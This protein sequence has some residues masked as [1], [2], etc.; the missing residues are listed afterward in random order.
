M[1]LFGPTME[2]DLLNNFDVICRAKPPE[3]SRDLRRYVPPATTV[4]PNFQRSAKPSDWTIF[5][6]PRIS[7]TANGGRG[8]VHTSNRE[9]FQT[10]WVKMCS[11]FEKYKNDCIL[12]GTSRKLLSPLQIFN[13]PLIS[14]PQPMTKDFVRAD[15][16]SHGEINFN[17][18]LH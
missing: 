12:G 14:A 8:Y 17:C 5:P 7:A 4:A 10:A 3:D 16:S 1:S 13:S 2:K 6:F 9:A 18:F 11:L 15:A